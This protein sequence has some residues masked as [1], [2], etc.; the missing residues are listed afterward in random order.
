M[1]KL[2]NYT[3]KLTANMGLSEEKAKDVSAE[4]LDHLLLL[5]TDFIQSGLDEVT[6][7]S[8]AIKQFEQTDS[9]QSNLAHYAKYN[10]KN[11]RFSFKLWLKSTLMMALVFF[12]TLVLINF[13]GIPWLIESQMTLAYLLVSVTSIFFFLRNLNHSKYRSLAFLLC[14]LIFLGLTEL[15]F[16]G[17]RIYLYPKAIFSEISYLP[18][19]SFI[20]LALL[21]SYLL[22][23]L[24]DAQ[25]QISHYKLLTGLL[26]GLNTLLIVLYVLTPNRWFFLRKIIMSLLDA[27]ISHVEKSIF[28]MVINHKLFIP[29]I[30]LIAAL[31]ILAFS[32]KKHLAPRN[33]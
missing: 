26:W 4:I 24:Q 3:H 32:L 22:Y 25:T 29:N 11:N 31:L 10:N 6:A 17:L 8:K 33:L 30:G 2:I 21:S 9:F 14:Q 23:L 1:K 27:D 7:E 13:I 18:E 12:F 28:Y 5:K 19:F 15:A 16:W 20:L